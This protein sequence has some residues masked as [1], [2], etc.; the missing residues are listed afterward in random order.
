MVDQTTEN[1]KLTKLR[2]IMKQH[3][4]D[5]YLVFHND[6]HSSEYIADCDERVKFISGFSGSNGLCLVTET[7]ALMWTDGR[8]YLQAQKQLEQGWEMKKMEAGEPPYFEWIVNNLPKGIRIGADPTQV[9][10]SAFKNRSK[11]F[12]EKEIDMVTIPQNLV[13]EVWGTEKPDMP[14]A[15]VYPHE[16]KYTGQTLREKVQSIQDK[17]KDKKVDV[18]LVTTLDDINWSLNLR[19]NDIKCNPVFFAYL[20]VHVESGHLDLFINK[21]KVNETVKESFGTETVNIHSYEEIDEY[22]AKLAADGKKIGFDENICNQKL[23]ESFEKSNPTHLAGLIELIKASKNPVEQEGM[24]D[25]NI[26]N[27]VSLVQYFA[28]LEDHLKNNPDSTLNEYTAQEKLEEFRKLQ[29]LYVGPSFET[30]SSIGPNGAV[31]HYKPEPET[32]LRM[33]N[34]EI[35][36]L[37]SGVQYFNG[38]TDITRTVHFAGEQ[39]TQEQK[40]MY[41]R[42]LLGTLDLERVVWPAKGTF[43]GQDFDALARRHLWAAGVDYNH[44]TGHGVGHFNCVHEG[45]QGISRR[46]MVKLELGMCVSDEPG[47]YKDGEY[48]IRIENVIMVVQHPQH[49]NRYKFENLTM[50]PYCKEL[51]DVSLLN[52]FDLQYIN[53]FHARCE[54]ILT[55]RLQNDPLALDYLKRQCTPLS[56]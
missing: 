55:P 42:V 22:L 28:W 17:L 7:Q 43:S 5:A 45:P 39:P 13:D 30:I 53:E 52:Q 47:Y 20:V 56:Q 34:K 48:G 26:K 40:Q 51:I 50:T 21:A 1:A 10:V 32:A 46:N 16:V 36:L 29:D 11:Y 23:Y 3:N 8:Y 19:G 9:S 14:L 31:I 4:L 27:S 15:P 38:T 12:K 35:Y 6:A 25:S 44:G 54:E 18:L 33:N 41:T 37:D 49:E 2:S 24:R